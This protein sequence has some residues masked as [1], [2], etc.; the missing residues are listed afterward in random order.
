MKNNFTFMK[1]NLRL[2]IRT[3]NLAISCK[4]TRNPKN[5]VSNELY[6]GGDY[7]SFILPSGD[8]SSRISLSVN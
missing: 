8:K 7:D 4:I 5:L 1:C 6:F 3:V 2:I